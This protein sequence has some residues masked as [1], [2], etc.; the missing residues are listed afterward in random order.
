VIISSYISPKAV[1]G[2]PSQIEGRGLVAAAPIAR[3]EIVAI[4]G[5]HIV[6]TATLRALPDRLRNSDI[7]ITDEFHL[8]A[9]E[10]DE[11]EPVMPAA[12]ISGRHAALAHPHRPAAAG[13]GH[14]IDV[15]VQDHPPDSA[16]E[17]VRVR[18]A[19]QRAVGLAVVV[20]HGVAHGLAD[21]VHVTGHVRRGVVIQQ[22]TSAG[23][24][25]VVEP[26][27]GLLPGRVLRSADREPNTDT[28]PWT[29]AVGPPPLT[30]SVPSRRPGPVARCRITAML[31]VVPPGP[32]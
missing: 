7:R 23:G 32:A 19:E 6:E 3:D 1:K 9:V 27:P 14:R 5:G 22:G 24:A 30:N 25:E 18:G 26:R 17:Q 8:A 13:S 15:P 16:R 28:K 21:Q 31:I 4:K 11:Y 29:W 10:D 20:Q 12:G 2:T